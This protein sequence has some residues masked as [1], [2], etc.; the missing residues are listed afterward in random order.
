VI[1]PW[2]LRAFRI[3]ESRPLSLSW[4]EICQTALHRKHQEHQPQAR[5]RGHPED[6]ARGSLLLPDERADTSP[7][8]DIYNLGCVLCYLITEAYPFRGNRVLE[9]MRNVVS[10]LADRSPPEIPIH[11]RAAVETMLAID[12][13]D[14]FSSAGELATVLE[15]VAETFPGAADEPEKKSW[16]RRT[17]HRIWRPE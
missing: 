2:P 1:G 13:R 4:R 12:P 14:R 7:A 15:R 17:W 3:A 5:D 10:T 11:V 16:W 9:L 6:V 8:T